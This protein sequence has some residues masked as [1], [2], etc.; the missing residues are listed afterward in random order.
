MGLVDDINING[1]I[2]IERAIELLPSH[3]DWQYE[4]ATRLRLIEEEE[5]KKRKRYLFDDVAEAYLK[6]LS[7]NPTDHRKRPEAFYCLAYIYALSNEITKVQTYYQK[8][9][10][11]E[12]PKVRLPCFEAVKE[13]LF[14]PKMF[15]GIMLDASGLG[16][17][18]PLENTANAADTAQKML[19]NNC[20][21]CLKS[22]QSLRCKACKIVW[23]CDRDC[24]VAHWKRHKVDCKRLSAQN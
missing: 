23:Y 24:Q 22:N 7:S 6:F 16:K 3:T 20:A 21:N 14:P 10:E 8:G 1:L 12:D 2:A 9:L 11:A 5:G 19:T 18:M 15:A 17:K 4:R 13:H